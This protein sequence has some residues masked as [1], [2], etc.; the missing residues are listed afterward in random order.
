[1][2]QCRGWTCN[3]STQCRQQ[4]F[5]TMLSERSFV[6]VMHFKGPDMTACISVPQD[7]ILKPLACAS[8]RHSLCTVCRPRP[9]GASRRDLHLPGLRVSMQKVS[10]AVCCGRVQSARGS[11]RGRLCRQDRWHFSSPPVC[12]DV[13]DPAHLGSHVGGEVVGDQEPVVA[14]LGH[15]VHAVH[16]GLEVL[17]LPKHAVSDHVESL[18]PPRVIVLQRSSVLFSVCALH[19][20]RRIDFG[21]VVGVWDLQ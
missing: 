18:H 4:R 8:T 15:V 21:A 11:T 6:V 10:S 12:P 13:R 17:H 5:A 1:M 16:Q 3:H 7:R 14:G 9:A 20:H 19:Q 2:S